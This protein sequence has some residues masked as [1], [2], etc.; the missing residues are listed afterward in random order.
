MVLSRRI[1]K[2]RAPL[3]IKRGLKRTVRAR[4]AAVKG[5]GA[6]R[7]RKMVYRHHRRTYRKGK[8]HHRRRSNYGKKNVPKYTTMT[9]R[10]ITA[11]NQDWITTSSDFKPKKIELDGKGLWFPDPTTGAGQWTAYEKA[12]FDSCM[13]KKPL[14][15]HVYIKDA[16]YN[17]WVGNSSK[18][19]Q[20]ANTDATLRTWNAPFE[21]TSLS[22]VATEEIIRRGKLMPF[23]R[24]G[25]RFHTIFKQ[26]YKA[27]ANLAYL[28][29]AIY[30]LRHDQLT[31]EA[32]AMN[33]TGAVGD[34]GTRLNIDSWVLPR[35]LTVLPGDI[36]GYTTVFA[37]LR[38]DLVVAIKWQL[39]GT[40]PIILP[41][42]RMIGGPTLVN[43][44]DVTNGRSESQQEL[45]QM[46][47]R[48]DVAM[49]EDGEQYEYV[50][51]GRPRTS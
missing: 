20:V 17:Q 24:N 8:R 12:R 14:S 22:E 50:R 1:V 18:A 41:T 44:R 5:F 30:Q 46:A 51:I 31:H 35:L 19:V 27:R 33:R 39:A 6:V 45:T 10:C 26:Q 7:R 29:D 38:A 2:R 37:G 23:S 36:A 40:E 48:L 49:A 15:I 47:Q 4:S 43:G 25:C 34:T 16:Y 9:T 42:K 13:T 11:L 28:S 32:D 3:R 21:D